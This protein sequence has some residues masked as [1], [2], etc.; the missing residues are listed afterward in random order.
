MAFNLEFKIYSETQIYVLSP[1]EGSVWS[2]FIFIF[3]VLLVYWTFQTTDMLILSIKIFYTLFSAF[4]NSLVDILWDS[5]SQYHIVSKAQFY[6]TGFQEKMSRT[7]HFHSPHVKVVKTLWHDHYTIFL[8]FISFARNVK[9]F[10][11]SSK[12]FPKL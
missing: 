9:V 7:C 11:N 1:F 8:P 5:K 12:H 2:I 4:H 6:G 3:K 10:Q